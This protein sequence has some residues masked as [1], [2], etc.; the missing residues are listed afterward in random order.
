MPKL[1]IPKLNPFS[2]TNFFQ[3]SVEPASIEILN[4]DKITYAAN[5]DNLSELID[6]PSYHFVQGD[7]AD[8]NNVNKCIKQFKKYRK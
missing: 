1:F 4:F 7:I 3:Q 8:E 6:N 5:L 2:P